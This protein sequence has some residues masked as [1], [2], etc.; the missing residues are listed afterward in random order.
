L[1]TF[2]QETRFRRIKNL[3]ETYIERPLNMWVF[4]NYP[5]LEELRGLSFD[6]GLNN[7]GELLVNN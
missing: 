6:I 4:T 5:N 7:L 3:L 1:K 2:T